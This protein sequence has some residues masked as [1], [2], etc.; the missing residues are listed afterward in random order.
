MKK[1]NKIKITTNYVFLFLVTLNVFCRS[2]FTILNKIESRSI[3]EYHIV[4]KDSS[5][6]LEIANNKL[7][8]TTISGTTSN[9]NY[10]NFNVNIK[11]D[12]NK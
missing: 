12:P 2:N 7:S 8:N 5:F 4:E 9:N 10:F 11:K 3:D 6:P 1:V